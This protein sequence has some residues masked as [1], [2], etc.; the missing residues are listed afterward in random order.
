MNRVQGLIAQGLSST[1]SLGLRAV[2][3]GRGG[4]VHKSLVKF[5][6]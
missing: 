6:V 1:G 2:G 3:F 4:N 5:P